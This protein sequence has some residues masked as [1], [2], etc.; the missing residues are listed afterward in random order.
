MGTNIVSP[1][2]PVLPIKAASSSGVTSGWL[3]VTF[4]SDAGAD[5]G[6]VAMAGTL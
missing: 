1:V 6:S 4:A 3:N 2:D 5:A